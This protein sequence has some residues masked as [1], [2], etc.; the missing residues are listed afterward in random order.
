[1]K[2]TVKQGDKTR[3]LQFEKGENLLKILHKNGIFIMAY[4]GGKGICR[5]CTVKFLNNPPKPFELER[6]TLGNR[7]DKG[8]RLACLHN[9]END[10]ILEIEEVKP[11]FVDIEAKPCCDNDKPHIAIDIGTTTIAISFIEKCQIEKTV[12]L[13]NPQIAF[14]SDVI[15]RIAYSNEGGFETLHSIITDTIKRS[16]SNFK[17]PDLMILCANPTMLSFFLGLNPKSIGEYPYTPP[18]K[19]SITSEFDGIKVY[20]PPVISAFVGSDITA[21]LSILPDDEDFLFV[22]IG[23][24]CEFILKAGKNYYSSSVPAGPALEGSNIDYGSIAQDGAIYK[25]SLEDGFKV[26]TINGKKPIGIAGSGLVSAISLLKS[27]G[28]IDKNGKLV[29]AWEAE[30]PFSLISRIKKDGFMLVEDIYLT[31]NSIRNFQLVKA[32]LNA[33]IKLLLDKV[34]VGEPKKVFVGGGFSKTLTKEEII[35]SGLLSF[36]EEFVMLG[37][38]SIKGGV[39]LF[40]EKERVKIEKIA[41]KIEY[42]EIANEQRFEKLYIKSMNFDV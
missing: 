22:D 39:R 41:E 33:G 6:K 26:Y 24:N 36:G 10:A 37:N 12:N 7:V 28:I 13:L 4:C 23:T 2:L 31:Q 5:K 34:G 30:A 42:I 21:A 40:C 15:T 35:G 17:K 11:A 25:V 9:L 3:S 29:E 32:S 14:G 38:S 20:V 27:Y 16:I 19:D 18:F 8:Y 1:M